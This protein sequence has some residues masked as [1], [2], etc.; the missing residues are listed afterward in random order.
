VIRRISMKVAVDEDL[1]VGTGNCVDTC[2]EVFELVDGVSH[3]KVDVVPKDMEK[4][5]KQAV[6]ECPVSAIEIV[7]E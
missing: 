5:A 4:Q 3:V 1:C 2:P 7:E 6:E